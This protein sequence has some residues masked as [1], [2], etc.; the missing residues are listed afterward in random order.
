MGPEKPEPSGWHLIAYRE[1]QELDDLSLTKQAILW[2][3]D[4]M[5]VKYKAQMWKIVYK[6][7]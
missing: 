2:F 7:V 5:S 4:S 1:R 3:Y 6:N